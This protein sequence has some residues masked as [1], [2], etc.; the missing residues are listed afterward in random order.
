M[1]KKPK[2]LKRLVCLVL[3]ILILSCVVGWAINN[4]VVKNTGRIISVGFELYNP[5]NKTITEFKWKKLELNET[6]YKTGYLK[7]IGNVDAK[8]G[9]FTDNWNPPEAEQAVT[10]TWD[11][12]GDVILVGEGKN[13]TFTLTVTDDWELVTGF[14]DFSFDIHLVGKE[15]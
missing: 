3:T 7:N 8:A 4:F 6:Y 1:R 13:V 9:M 5:K 14:T 12:E 10:F 2:N 11:A 15:A